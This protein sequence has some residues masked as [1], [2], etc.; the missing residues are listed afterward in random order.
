VKDVVTNFINKHQLLLP[1]TTVLVAVSGGPDSMALLHYFKTIREEWDLRIIALSVD[2]ELRG[3]ESREDLEYVEHICQEWGIEFVGTSIDVVGYK[4]KNHVGTQ[5]AARNV[6]YDFFTEQMLLF[7]AN[8]LAFGHHGDDQAETMI[9]RMVRTADSSSLSGIPIKREFA[10]G[11]I[12]RPFLCIARKDIDGY[13]QMHGIHP[14]IDPSN[15]STDYTRNFYRIK[16]L[17]LLKS[18][19]SNIHKTIQHLSESLQED[20]E[21]LQTEAKKLF[22]EVVDLIENPRKATVEIDVF[23]SHASALQRRVYHLILNYLYQGDLPTDLTYSQQE[24]FFSLMGNN[25]G[26]VQID[27]PRHLK[28]E[29]AYNKLIFYFQ[30]EEKCW[31]EFHETISVPSELILPNGNKVIAT[32]MEEVPNQNKYTYICLADKVELPLH[33]RTRQ[34]GDRMYWPGLNGSKKIKDI[35]IDAK[36]P[37]QERNSWPLVTDNKGDILWLVG[38]KKRDP[39]PNQSDSLYIQLYYHQGNL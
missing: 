2:H 34:D 27:F 26:N 16:V 10:G 11:Y 3:E 25:K 14:R 19:N 21:F 7:K 39:I 28:V 15:A 13:C 36:I 9:M 33:I 22:E 37:L 12:I 35:F 24:E 5:V 31:P 17:P 8:Y 20:E 18:K 30:Q 23:Q 1:R 29:K 6:R 4:K 38:L 32:Y